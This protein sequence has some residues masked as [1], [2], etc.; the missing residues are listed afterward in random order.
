MP[1]VDK[2][3]SGM[4][5]FLPS[6]IDKWFLSLVLLATPNLTWSHGADATAAAHPAHIGSGV[7]MLEPDDSLKIAVDMFGYLA[8]S[9]TSTLGVG[10]PLGA[11][12]KGPQY[13]NQW[14]YKNGPFDRPHLEKP[15]LRPGYEDF[16]Y[17]PMWQPDQL[18]LR[19]QYRFLPRIWGSISLGYDADPINT[20]T[21]DA[22]H[23]PTLEELLL[24]WAPEGTPGLAFSFGQQTIAG[25]YSPIFDHFTLIHSEFAGLTATYEREAYSGVKMEGAGAVGQEG[26]GRLKKT[27]QSNTNDVG[28]PGTAMYTD[29]IRSRNHFLANIR[30]TSPG[31]FY[32]GFL[33]EYQSLPEDSTVMVPLAATLFRYHWRRSQGWQA[34]GI[35][36][37]A[38]KFWEYHLTLS[39]GEGDVNMAWSGPDAISVPSRV[40]PDVEWTREG[41]ALSQVIYWGGFHDGRWRFDAG[42]WTQWRNPAKDAGYFYATLSTGPDSILQLKSQYFRAAKLACE[43]SFKLSEFMTLGLR[44]DYFLYLDP[45]SHANTLEPLTDAALRPVE[46][47]LPDGSTAQMQGPSKWEREAANAQILSPFAQM[48]L[49]EGF[50]ARAGW[51][52]AWYSKAVNRQGSIGDFHANATL[53]AWFTYRFDQ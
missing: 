37:Y 9:W 18:E 50:H 30:F 21:E 47:I 39:H 33:G 26:V 22:L 28:D 49:G 10:T 7:D 15:D 24:K 38:G 52:G 44:Y 53:A 35:C 45:L 34:G 32:L 46:A 2:T 16:S 25:S 8:N 20:E 4:P 13:Y 51:S 42:I 40:P 12:G 6:Q 1:T 41:S 14:L 48:D 17:V 27:V 23:A 29:G 36:G 43:P 5:L 11:G 19:T 31:G 3:Y